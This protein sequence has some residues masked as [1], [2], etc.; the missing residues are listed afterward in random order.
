MASRICSDRR[1]EL[2]ML[3]AVLNYDLPEIGAAVKVKA[4]QSVV[5]K[6]T[7]NNYVGVISLMKKLY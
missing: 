2:L 1:A 3:G 7:V 6:N 5:V 4:M